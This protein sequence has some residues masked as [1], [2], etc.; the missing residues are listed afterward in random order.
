[1]LQ[2]VSFVLKTMFILIILNTTQQTNFKDQEVAKSTYGV[3]S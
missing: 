3:E 2:K 1:M